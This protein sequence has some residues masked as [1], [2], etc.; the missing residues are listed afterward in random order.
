MQ[1]LRK[2]PKQQANK[3]IHL[4]RILL[5][6]SIIFNLSFQQCM[7][8]NPQTDNIPYGIGNATVTII[9]NQATIIIPFAA[10]IN[11]ENLNHAKHLISYQWFSS[12]CQTGQVNFRDKTKSN[13]FLY[14]LPYGE[15]H[16]SFIIFSFYTCLKMKVN[17]TS[18]IQGDVLASNQSKGVEYVDVN[19][20]V[21]FF[22]WRTK[23]YAIPNA[24]R[25]IRIKADLSKEGAQVL[26]DS[27]SWT[28]NLIDNKLTCR[29]KI[30]SINLAANKSKCINF[31]QDRMNFRSCREFRVLM[32]Y[33]LHF[34][35]GR[36]TLLLKECRDSINPFYIIQF[37]IFPIA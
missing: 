24:P 33:I 6:L 21:R 18:I 20:Y 1:N 3:F 22:S 25:R 35:G 37:F 36:K 5:N 19:P 17:L 8:T 31:K 4:S 16:Y 30:K 14:N 28:Y 32:E 15:I 11:P 29:V 23:D 10:N 7:A 9:G 26:M 2:P 34:I 13:P 12:N 27:S